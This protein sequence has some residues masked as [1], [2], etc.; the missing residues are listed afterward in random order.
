MKVL[1][2]DL[3]SPDAFS[4]GMPH[5]LFTRL[6]KES[7]VVWV[8]E[9]PSADGSFAGGPGFWAVMRHA[10]V[11]HVSRHPEIFSSFA[12]TIFLRDPRPVDI[13]MFQQ[14]MINMDPPDHARMRRIV[15]VAFTP[16]EVTK[17]MDEVRE[18]ARAVVDA[19][20]DKE[21]GDFVLDVASELPL[22]VLS[23]V[24][25]IPRE[26]RHLLFEW[27]NR[28]V[29]YDDPEYR[30]DPE[31]F[32]AVFR[33]M[34]AYADDRT[35]EK[36]ATPDDTVWSRV[37]NA[38]LDG[39]P[40]TRS[41]LDRFFQLLVGAGNE[42]TRNL[43]SGGLVALADHP[44]QWERLKANPDLLPTAVEEMLRWVTPVVQFR[45]TATQDTEIAGQKIA[46]GDK[47]VIFYPS[48]NRDES[49]FDDPFTFDIGRDP[50]PHLA[51]GHGNHLCLG[52]H[53]ARL[54]A[55]EMFAEMIR[56]L[57]DIHLAGPPERLRSNLL[58][59]IRHLPVRYHG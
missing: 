13:P 37:A 41:E 12:G 10:D 9:P 17:L 8:E 51:F 18:H 32:R 11:A 5:E 24:L 52:A 23:D 28:L 44:D 56:R 35:K 54:E 50:N 49:V 40:L 39:M 16:R 53:L 59:S 29:G 48:A 6:R 38:E 58:N 42:T 45:R 33:E 4:D 15:G 14:M 3:G 57:P 43:I 31:Q 55:R 36:R 7:P 25:G 21:E 20:V 22:L 27:T 47:V 1:D 2:V 46:E 34:F 26:D 30:G 19:V